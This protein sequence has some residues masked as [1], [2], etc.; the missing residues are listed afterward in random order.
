[1]PSLRARAVSAAVA[2]VPLAVCWPGGASNAQTYPA[3]PITIVVPLAAGSGMDTIVRLYGDQLAQS[4]GKSVV[5]ENKPGAATMLGT[6]S[7]ASAPADGYTLLVATSSA[8]AI[9]PVLYKKI[10]YDPDKDFVPIAYYVK[11][12]FVLVVNPALPVHSVPELIKYAKESATPL[13]YSSPGAGVAQHLSIEF[14]KQRFGVDMTHVPYRNTP[15]SITDIAAGHVAL[16]FVEAGAGLPL[17]R[18]GRLRAVAVSASSRLG[19]LPEVPTFAEASGAADFEA[20][21]W[22]IL[23]APAATPKDV[24][25]KLHGEMTRIMATPD[26]QKRIVDL[27]LI[28]VQSPSVAGIRSYVHSE[29][30]KWGSLVRK[31]RLVGTE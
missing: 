8:M 18:D 3:R 26:M 30:D 6:A 10:S 24:V 15:Q 17:I 11:S 16:G 25:E 14:L 12:P 23:F 1:M 13:S 7:V 5:V 2:L 19:V 22:H 20:V 28:P 21:S 29:Q 31:L 27:G 4:L 9:N